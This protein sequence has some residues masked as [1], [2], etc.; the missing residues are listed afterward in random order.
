MMQR[1]KK[2]STSLILAVMMLAVSTSLT[3]GDIKPSVEV[4]FNLFYNRNYPRPFSFQ[5][6][7]AKLFLDTYINDN[8]TALIEF[9]MK[10]NFR[11]GELERAYFIQHDL[12]LNSQLILGQFRSPFGYYDAFTVSRAMIKDAPLAPDSAMPTMKLRDLD[13]GLLW[14]SLGDPF[15]FGLAVVNGN[16]INSLSDDNNF[17]DIVAHALYSFESL[18]IGINGYYG[19]KNSLHP[20]GSVKEYSDVEVTAVGMETM[21]LLDRAVIAGEAIV[22]QY[23]SL[24]SAGAYVMLNYDLGNIVRT[25]R[26]VSRVEVFDPNRNVDNDERIQWGQGFLYSISRGYT[27]K[28]EWTLNFEQPRVSSNEIFFELEYEL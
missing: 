23:G 9:V 3:A 19:R 14:Q 18:Q 16:G 26:Y 17:K 15:S 28:L 2:C 12:P 8:S 22:R 27:A 20:D 11:H 25:L 7:E 21:V 24:Q 6:R 1:S 10:E 4:E 5:F 13:V